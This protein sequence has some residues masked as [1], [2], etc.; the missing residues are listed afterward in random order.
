MK[1]TIKLLSIAILFGSLLMIYPAV[2]NSYKGASGSSCRYCYTDSK[3]LK[4]SAFMKGCR[5]ET[6]R[7]S[8]QP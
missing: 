7:C 3:V 5:M 8:A 6:S 4:P 1:R 2:T